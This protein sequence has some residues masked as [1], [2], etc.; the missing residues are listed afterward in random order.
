MT[1]QESTLREQICEVG[2]N[3]WSLGFV[4]ANDGN[5]S[6]KLDDGTFLATPTGTSKR[7]LTPDMLIKMNEKN[8]VVDCPAGFR[9]SSEFKMHLRCY[10]ERPEIKAVVHAHPPTATGF[11]I[12]HIPLDEYT[13]PEAIIFLGSVPIAPYG[14]PGSEEVPDSIVPFLPYH[15]TILLMNHGA[16]TV[17]VDLTQAFYRMETLEHFAKVSL[18]ARQLGGAKELERA[19]IDECC[20]IAKAFPIRHPGYRKYSL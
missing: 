18:I 6:V 8:E 16:L 17:G 10:R 20:E 5:I 11:A 13:M 14:T 4:A 2:H 9:P 19:K 12:A 7:I 3:L 15:D 1:E